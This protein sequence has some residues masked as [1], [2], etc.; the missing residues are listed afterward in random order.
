[1]AQSPLRSAASQL[2]KGAK[3]LT[4]LSRQIRALDALS[5][6]LTPAQ[7]DDAL[8]KVAGSLRAF[9][10]TTLQE[11]LTAVQAEITVKEE[12]ASE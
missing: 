7:R 1:M 4:D 5:G 2:T 6:S 3:G 10:A 12:A 8:S 9:R 11:V